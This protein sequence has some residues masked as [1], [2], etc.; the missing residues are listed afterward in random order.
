MRVAWLGALLAFA[1]I[2]SADRII[3]VPTGTKLLNR[4]VRLEFMGELRKNNRYD[5][6]LGVGVTKD[7]ELELQLDRF[8]RDASLGTFNLSYLFSPAI[9]DTAP[10]L[11][12]GVQDAMDRTRDGRMYY[13]ALTYRL[14][15]D[16]EFNSKTPLEMTFGGGFGRRNGMFV[17]LML[18]FTWSFRLLA[19]ND[20]R[21]VTTGFEYRPIH[22]LGL[23]AMWRDNE[24]LFGVRFTQRF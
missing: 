5:T 11:A 13:I 2:S 7:I 18:P 8:D 19:E 14:G 15:L 4:Q 12:F 6:F 24:T 16:G 1:T 23:R 10:G 22:G 21:R 20:L 3:L 9:V 17:G